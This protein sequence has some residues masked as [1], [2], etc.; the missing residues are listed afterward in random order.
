MV[1]VVVV[2]VCVF[3]LILSITL[4]WVISSKS[5]NLP[6]VVTTLSVVSFAIKLATY[7]KTVQ[8]V[9]THNFASLVDNK[10][11]ARE[12]ARRETDRG[13]LPGAVV[14][15]ASKPTFGHCG[16]SEEQCHSDQW[17]GGGCFCWNHAWHRISCI[18]IAAQWC[19][20]NEHPE[21]LTNMF[22]NQISNSLWRA[23]AHYQP[24][25]SHCECN[26]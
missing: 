7:S 14:V 17:E 15:P 21:S 23:T 20:F 9:K 4:V 26:R 8:H 13:R 22:L 19:T 5:T 25:W 18:L 10:A 12:P 11:M 6:S 24:C 1:I 16:H 2:C 3:L